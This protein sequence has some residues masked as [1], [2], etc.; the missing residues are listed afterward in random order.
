M[1]AKSHPW[2]ADWILGERLG[3]GGQGLTNLVTRT[4]A[5][6]EKGALKILKNNKDAQARGRMRREVV[7]LGHASH[8]LTLLREGVP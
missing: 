5:P 1:A 3:K 8:L 4:N 2:D 6:S 7:S